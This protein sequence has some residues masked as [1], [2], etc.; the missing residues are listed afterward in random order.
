[1]DTQR[2]KKTRSLGANPTTS[3]QSTSG[4]TGLRRADQADKH[5]SVPVVVPRR[6]SEA[7]RSVEGLK[8]AD[9]SR[10]SSKASSRDESAVRT[11]VPVNSGTP[12]PGDQRRASAVSVKSN[13][14]V[15]YP[16][17]AALDV[18]LT[19]PQSVEKDE[20]PVLTFA[21][22]GNSRVGKSVFIRNALDLRRP[23]T[24]QVA[25]SKVLLG[26][27][28]Y[29]LQLVEVPLD[30]VTFSCN[31]ISWS[32]IP[33]LADY[34]NVEG[35]LC[36]YDVSEKSSLEGIHQL[37]TALEPTNKTV[38][39]VSCKVDIPLCDHEIGPSFIDR[40]STEFPKIAFEEASI[41]SSD[42]AKRCLLKILKETLV[43]ARRESRLPNRARSGSNTSSAHPPRRLSQGTSS[44]SRSRSQHL[45][46]RSR[47]RDNLLSVPPPPVIESEDEEGEESEEETDEESEEEADSQNL[48]AR[49]M[50]IRVDTA[51][52]RPK[53]RVEKPQTPISST[54][55]LS[56]RAYYSSERAN[57]VVPQTP[58]SYAGAT[59]LRRG[60][61]DTAGSKTCK[62]FLDIDDESPADDTSPIGGEA[63]SSREGAMGGDTSYSGVPFPELVDKLLAMPA[64]KGDRK[65]ISSF[66]CLYRTFETPLSLLM[67]IIER[68]MKTDKSDM[69]VF[70]KTAELLRYLSVLGLWTAH[71]PGDFADMTVRDTI[72]T[73]VAAIEKNKSFAPSAKQIASNLQTFAPDEDEDWAFTGPGRPAAGRSPNG[74]RNTNSH[75]AQARLDTAKDA[76]PRE[77]RARMVRNDDHSDS[78]EDVVTPSSAR[79]SSATSAASSLL[80]GSQASSL[81]SENLHHLETARENA[82]KLRIAP[83]KELISKLQWHIFMTYTPEELAIEITRMDWTM[84]TAIRPRDFVRYVTIPSSQRSSS[85][86]IDYIGMM[87]K[88]FNHLALFVSSMI[89]TRDKPKHRAK[90]VEKFMDL[91]W[92]VRQMN[93]YHALGAIVAALSGEEI[94]RLVQTHE[95]ISQDQQK[96][97]MRL[98]ILMGHQKSHAAYR[99]AWENSPG[100]RIPYLPRIQEDLTKAAQG[101]PTFVGG[102]RNINWRKFEIMGDT[103]VGVQRSQ[104]QPYTFADRAARGESIDKLILETKLLEHE[105]SDRATASI[106]S[107]DRLTGR[108]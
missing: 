75:S 54:E 64:S 35:I 88:H 99:M 16:Y 21:V 41:D 80:R 92:K 65:F 61:A 90:M 39:L 55:N 50:P 57:R 87:T 32:S 9:R 96:Q 26:G 106:A 73:F 100:E 29:R 17:C 85:G 53:L 91:A 58:E 33:E 14:Q 40:V 48:P 83:G 78:D 72:S 71:Y 81:T 98:K 82:R 15:G 60:S 34:P 30:S 63:G 68:F 51:N 3:R 93:N 28:L 56:T 10:R 108:I 79:H 27:S 7:N 44:R 94:V 62:T 105:V 37:L 69:V 12:Q 52:F 42:S 107:T 23:N 24:S 47:S 76:K 18:L 36:L 1:M 11:P 101:N 2:A 22:V 31:T 77:R 103:I 70:T 13:P 20:I 4:L 19:L 74:R 38:C 104:E 66:L 89:L 49:K 8:V 43:A 86:R 45:P 67:A 59:P 46:A 25:T 5:Y 95:L 97:F 6:Q 84:Y 102:S